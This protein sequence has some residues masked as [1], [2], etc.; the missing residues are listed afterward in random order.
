MGIPAGMF[1]C[2]IPGLKNGKSYLYKNRMKRLLPAFLMVILLASCAGNQKQFLAE[3]YQKSKTTGSVSI[4]TIDRDELGDQFPEH[5][6]GSLRPVERSLFD[7]ELAAALQNQTRAQVTGILE[8]A[9]F[10][11]TPF[12]LNFYPLSKDSLPILSPI[13]G[14]TL[15]NSDAVSNFALV[16]DQFNFT[17]IEVEAGSNTYA[18]HESKSQSF[19]NFQTKYLIWDNTKG[20][21][22]AWGEAM[23]QR[24]MNPQDIP[25]MYSN[26][27]SDVFFQIIEQSPFVPLCAP[28][29]RYGEPYFPCEPGGK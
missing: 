12:E 5:N 10:Q 28:F 15:S 4:L 23:S 13:S 17:P 22:V 27:L 29:I 7:R 21:A 19:M 11:S 8:S 1:T 18:G 9:I 24:L 25:E 3:D 14:T 2:F 20:E 16:L 26:L 6:F